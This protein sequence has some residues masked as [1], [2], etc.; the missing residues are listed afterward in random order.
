MASCLSV[1]HSPSYGP[2]ALAA[3]VSLLVANACRFNGH[4]S[5]FADTA[6]TLQAAATQAL[7]VVGQQQQQQDDQRAGR[8][9]RGGGDVG[10]RRGRTHRC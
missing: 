3:D 1:L 4:D 6:R 5:P 2:S 10:K 9:G 7:Q 8:A